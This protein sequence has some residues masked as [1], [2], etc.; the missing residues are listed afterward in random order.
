M[1]L[2][3]FLDQPINQHF[4]ASKHKVTYSFILKHIV[5]KLFVENKL[6]IP[7]EY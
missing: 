2:H 1:S 5:I 6:N 3:K 4:F 7:L